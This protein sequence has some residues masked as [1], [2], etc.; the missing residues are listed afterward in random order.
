VTNVAQTVEAGSD[1]TINE[2]DIAS[3]SG[4][5]TDPGNDTHTI[6]WDFGDGTTATGTLTPTH[7]Y[8]DNGEYTVTLTVTDDDGGVGIDTL[9]VTVNNL[10]PSLSSIL[11]PTDP[12]Q[13]GTEITASANFSDPGILDTHTAQWAWGD[14]NFSE[15]ISC[16]GERRF[17]ICEQ[18]LYVHHSRRL[19]HYS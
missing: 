4:N 1:Q 17:R 7:V 15:G 16:Y 8:A 10:A 11:A 9:N 3:F 14:G 12:V 2:G 18:F 5:F 19:Y 6:D 13:V